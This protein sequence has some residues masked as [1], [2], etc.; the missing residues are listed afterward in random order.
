MPKI[1]TISNESEDSL[2]ASSAQ[3]PSSGVAADNTRE[4]PSWVWFW[5][6]LAAFVLP[7]IAR[8]F[9]PHETFARVIYSEFG[10]MENVTVISLLIGVFIGIRLFTQ[11]KAFPAQWIGWWCLIIALGCFY[12]AG[13][14]ISWGQHFVGWQTPETWS[15]LGPEQNETNLHNLYRVFNDHPR[16]LLAV[17]IVISALIA[18]LYF[19]LKNIRF[20]AASVPYWLWPTSVA[21]FTSFLC[22]GVNFHKR[23]AKRVLDMPFTRQEAIWVEESQEVFFALFLMIYLLSI[24]MRMKRQK[25]LQSEEAHL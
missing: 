6:P 24:Y 2:T 10:V 15:A 3:N 14:E 21:I 22:V 20:D 5:V 8:P 12:M 19:K 23:F 16:S 13:E 11:R 4:L 7:Y 18:P 17:L 1:P 9:M 25:A